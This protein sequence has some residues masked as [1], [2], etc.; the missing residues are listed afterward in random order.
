MDENKNLEGKVELLRAV[1]K[2]SVAINEYDL[3]E[4]DKK[5]FKFGFKKKAIQWLTT[6]QYFT[7]KLMKSLV[8]IDDNLLQNVYQSFEDNG[9]KITS[10]SPSKESRNI[11]VMFYIKLYSSINDLEEI[12]DRAKLFPAPIIYKFAKDVVESIEK[13][14]P[15]IKNLNDL[16]GISI[17]ELIRHY[18]ELG[19]KILHSGEI[20]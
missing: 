5:Y 11:L 4:G 8:D 7:Q 18:D 20:K 13:Q 17:T 16:S 19:K 2:M 3:L 6:F 12:E 10:A 14:Y 15:D 1:M 9:I